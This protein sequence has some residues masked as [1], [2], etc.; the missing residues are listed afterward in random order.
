MCTSINLRLNTGGTY[1][2]DHLVHLSMGCL[3]KYRMSNV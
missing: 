3:K 1:E 2:M